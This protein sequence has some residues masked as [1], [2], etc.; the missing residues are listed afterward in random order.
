MA[1]NYLICPYCGR[2]NFKNHRGLRQHQKTS[3]KCQGKASAKLGDTTS[4][5]TAH[6]YMPLA[7]V[8]PAKVPRLRPKLDMQL[9]KLWAKQAYIESQIR[10]KNE[11]LDV[12]QPAITDNGDTE[13]DF[14]QNNDLIVDDS[15]S[16]TDIDS[17]S[18]SETSGSEASEAGNDEIDNTQVDPNFPNLQN[19]TGQADQFLRD[20]YNYFVAK[21]DHQVRSFTSSERTALRLMIQLRKKNASLNTYKSMM[22]WHLRETGKIG[23]HQQASDSTEYIG[24]EALINRLQKRYSF[25]PNLGYLSKKICLPYSK[26]SVE[27]V[28]YDAKD[29]M[30]RMLTDPRI[31]DTDYL[32][33]GNNPYEPPPDNLNYVQDL[34]TGLS[35]TETYK[36]LITKPGKQ[37]LLPVLFYIDA[38]N[39]GQMSDLP[40]TALT[41]SLGIFNRKARNQPHFWHILGYVP[42]ILDKKSRARRLAIESEHIDSIMAHQ[43]ALEGE[44]VEVGG[45]TSKAQDLH[46]ILRVIL[47]SYVS[48]QNSGF[49][50]DLTYNGKTYYGVEF[51]LFTPFIKVDTE[52]ADKLCG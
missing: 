20:C 8:H 22:D 37:V 2:S 17:N 23:S 43:D 6:E 33:F 38:A 34:N 1:S 19:N 13:F 31:K 26:T 25:T 51:V 24:R 45:K 5:T 18:G 7:T 41:M 42:E 9:A 11:A 14:P 40:I 16:G 36:E 49:I 39:T 29:I 12:K 52:E 30:I 46:S 44:G 48:L 27:V 10:S 32:F 28:H 35:Y 47:S 50:W 21:N 15:S 3:E 4:F